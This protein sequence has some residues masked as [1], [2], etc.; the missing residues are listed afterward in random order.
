MVGAVCPR[1]LVPGMTDGVLRWCLRRTE[2]G[3][4]GHN[5]YVLEQR[6]Q[7]AVEISL[8]QAGLRHCAIGPGLCCRSLV[9]QVYSL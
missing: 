4:V 5:V 2:L 6:V 7:R 9:V 8:Q 1:L 3:V